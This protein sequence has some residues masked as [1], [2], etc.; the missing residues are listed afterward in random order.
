MGK[1]SHGRRKNLTELNDAFRNIYLESEK[2]IVTVSAVKN[3]VDWFDNPIETTGQYAGIIIAVN[4]SEALIL[5]GQSA[6]AGADSLR[7][8]FWGRIH[9]GSR[10]EI[11]GHHLQD[12]SCQCEDL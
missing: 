12:G 6:V 4:S 8:T 3:D 7:V 5:T 10:T 9:G 2:S 1:V 11:P